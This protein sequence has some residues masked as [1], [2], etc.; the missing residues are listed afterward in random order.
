[1]EIVLDIIKIVISVFLII[2]IGYLFL[3][4]PRFSRRKKCRKSLASYA[5]RGLHDN[6]AGVPE[7][8]I[9][10]FLRAVEHGFGIELDVRLSKD[11]VIMVFHDDTLLRMCGI[12]KKVNELTAAEL[13]EISLLG[14]DCKIPTFDEVLDVVDGKIPLLIELKGTD[15]DTEL[16]DY[17]C[18]R[19]DSYK[20]AF[21]IESFNPLYIR[22]IKK[23]RPDFIR[24]QLVTNLVKDR[25]DGNRYLAFA[26]SNLLLNVL[27]RPDFIA[28]NRVYRRCFS[29]FVLSVIFKTPSFV[30]T[31]KE[32]DEHEFY[33]GRDISTIFEGF[34]PDK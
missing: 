24:G 10:A 19:L 16:C 17:V 12:D 15:R 25:W 30:W 13:K 11:K 4:A 27:C 33:S 9:S 28:F 5:H 31:I 14:T 32:I 3:V 26:M 2:L 34:V 22:K 29:V 8:S 1:M 20:G 6:N 23:L 7:N 18:K 21:C